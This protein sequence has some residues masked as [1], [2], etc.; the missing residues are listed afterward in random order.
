MADKAT[1]TLERLGIASLTRTFGKPAE[2]SHGH[3]RCFCLIPGGLAERAGVGPWDNLLD[4]DG[5]PASD[6][7]ALENLQLGSAVKITV[8]RGAFQ[9]PVSIEIPLELSIVKPVPEAPRYL[10]RSAAYIDGYRRAGSIVECQ[11]TPGEHME[12]LNDAARE[13][14]A[15][16]RRQ[17]ATLPARPSVA[18][19]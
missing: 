18:F 7:T 17:R 9:E 13:R 19:R 5:V 12:P 4:I 15:S 10:L 8:L 6:G 16:Y 2:I 14:F 11:A 3:A 1:M